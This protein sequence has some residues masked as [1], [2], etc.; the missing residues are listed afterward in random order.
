MKIVHVIESLDMAMGGPPAA[1]VGLAAAQGGL[2]HDVTIIANAAA[3]G[4]R[5]VTESPEQFP[6]LERVRVVAVSNRSPVDRVTAAG[7]REPVRTAI[8]GADIMHLHG[9]WQPLL[10]V[11]ARA[12]RTAGIPYVCTPRGM[13]HPWALSQKRWK[14]RLALMLGWRSILQHAAF[15]HAL[16]ER[17]ASHVAALGL[18]PSAKIIPNGVF[19]PQIDA[20]VDASAFL[21]LH[22]VLSG[23]RY[24]LFLGRL[25]KVKGLDYMARAFAAVCDRVADVDLVVA[26]PDGG[27]LDEFRGAIERF[28]IGDRV[29]IVG[30]LY[31]D[32][33]FAAMKGA[34]CFFQ[35]SRQEGFSMATIEAMASALP[36]VL[37]EECNF[38]EVAESGAGIVTPLDPDAFAAALI[39][40]LED[41]P[42]RDAMAD[43]ARRL[44][45][46]HYTWPSVAELSVSI[47]RSVLDAA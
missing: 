24:V 28:G 22:P 38:P 10:M 35:P 42:K 30:V 27:A 16:N 17:E 18:G 40:L 34:Y 20:V 12:A 41:Q 2:G 39:A 8:D 31:G 45:L 7:S 14:K 23:R 9:L 46:Q 21:A 13:L 43:A 25:H 44:V 47:Y 19:A 15:L 26:G 29:H 37:S 11:A 32:A 33:K 3:R 4:A 36:A 6:G 5:L 1:V